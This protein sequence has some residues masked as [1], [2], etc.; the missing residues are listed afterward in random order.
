M[1]DNKGKSALDAD[2]GSVGSK[3]HAD[4]EI[5]QAAESVGGPFDREG[6]VGKQFTTGGAVGSAG[7]KVAEQVQGEKTSVFD[8]DGAVG[9][10]FTGEF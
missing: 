9:K 8:K 10:Q 2:K 5:G 3:F 7:Q 1:A 6:A 4:G